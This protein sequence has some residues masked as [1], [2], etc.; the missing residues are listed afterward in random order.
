V[1]PWSPDGNVLYYR[2]KRDGHH[3]IWAQRLGPGKKPLGEPM[4]IQ[5]LHAAAFG[6][7]LMKPTDFSLAVGQD[8]LI[9]NLGKATGNLWTIK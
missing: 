2:S 4:A 6:L 8:R 1:D 7:Y 3:C 9:L 5:H